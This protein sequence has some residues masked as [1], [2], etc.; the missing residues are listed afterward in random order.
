MV[1]TTGSRN[2][3]AARPILLRFL[4]LAVLATVVF[5]LRAAFPDGAEAAQ[6]YTVNTTENTD[7]GSCDPLSTVPPEDCTLWEAIDAANDGSGDHDTINFLPSVF[8]PQSPGIIDLSVDAGALPIITE[9]L[10]INA[11]GAGV[12]VTGDGATMTAIFHVE[13]GFEPIDFIVLGGGATLVLRD[14]DGDAIA[15]HV[16]GGGNEY[17]VL[18][19]DGVDIGPGVTGDGIATCTGCVAALI[20]VT[21][22]NN[23]I[24]VDGDGIQLETDGTALSDSSMDIT[25]NEIQAGD[26]GVFVAY[27]G[28]LSSVLS[29]NVSNNP[30]IRADEDAIDLEY[31]DDVGPP[32]C[33]VVDSAINYTIDNN[34]EVVG[35]DQ[36]IDIDIDANDGVDLASSDADVTVNITDQKGP[37]SGGGG[38]GDP[39]VKVDVDICCGTSDSSNTVHVDNNQDITSTGDDAVQLHSDVCCGDDNDALITT[40]G[41]GAISTTAAGSDGVDIESDVVDGGNSVDGDRNESRVQV[42]NNDSITGDDDAVEVTSFVDD[43]GA[44]LSSVLVNGNGKILSVNDDGVDIDSNATNVATGS[45]DGDSNDSVIEVKD[46]GNI[47]G[48]DAGIV[49]NGEAD[50]DAS[51]TSTVTVTGNDD[52]SGDTLGIGIDSTGETNNGGD[53]NAS[54]VTVQSNGDITSGVDDAVDID[55]EAGDDDL[56]SGTNSND[57][58]STVKVNQ[59]G[60]LDGGDNAIDSQSAATGCCVGDPDSSTGNAAVTEVINNGEITGNGDNGLRIG[61][62][63]CCDTDNTN[64]VKVN[65][66]KSHITGVG[67]DGIDIGGTD[68]TPID[69]TLGGGTGGDYLC[70]SQNTVQVMNNVGNI[71]GE[72][73]S[74]TDGDGLELKACAGGGDYLI[75]C[76][77]EFDG[78]PPGSVTIATISGNKFVD[79]IDRGILIQAG[80]F[81]EL[82]GTTFGDRSVIRDNLIKGNQEW[83]GITLIS[84][85]GV[86]IGPNNVITENGGTTG[87]DIWEL[88]FDVL[89][90][91]DANTITQ[92]SIFD[93]ESLGIDLG[94]TGVDLLGALCQTAATFGNDGTPNG[95]LKAPN[96]TTLVGTKLVGIGCSGCRIEIFKAD[97][98]PADQPD[99]ASGDAVTDPVNNKGTGRQAGEGKTFLLAGTIDANGNFSVGL[100]GLNPGDKITATQTNNVGNTSEFSVNLQG[101][102]T[103]AGSCAVP[104][105]TPGGPTATPGGAT[106]TPTP[107]VFPTSTATPTRTNTP[108]P[109]STNTPT[110]T[111][112]AVPGATNTPTA[113]NTAVPPT[114]TNTA[115]PP[116]PTRTRTPTPPTPGTPKPPLGDVNG[117]GRVNAVDSALILQL[118][119]GLIDDLPYMN[120]ADVNLDG[121]VNAIDSALI[122]QFTAGIIPTLPPP[123]TAAGFAS[124]LEG[125][126]DW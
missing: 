85:S 44:L 80:A 5:G 105:S 48:A 41:N 75:S 4:L 38:A 109:T 30:F 102:P 20:D 95:C 98:T 15:L 56:T 8:T 84:A 46:N 43:E 59:N 124:V 90:P 87:I 74:S 107:F 32:G 117:D 53:D 54:T 16:G 31:C 94:N 82:S 106:S 68:D 65:N 29:V 21:I 93:N 99:D 17:D 64:T 77:G 50:G 116:T 19:I 72:G 66:N 57:N 111:S 89:R 70:C 25:G 55:S 9:S 78:D 40:N 100:C 103:G 6:K 122:L 119:A 11:V 7:D 28:D 35:G 52:I 62:L 22:T 27:N 12:V 110:A 24:E 14:V 2:S 83:G 114:A 120:N 49:I 92:N 97:E 118:V 73:S 63:V 76:L 126:L 58:T 37:I 112:T 60:A 67:D 113:T 33:E 79:S 81:G 26:E 3:L 88:V 69:P 108:T 51:N 123:G 101:P 36:A 10:T 104:T 23:D 91:A 115:V 71:T 61:S 13:P 34:G 47:I 39:A 1:H 86:V 96:L 45:T 125:L 121:D 42:N 18:T